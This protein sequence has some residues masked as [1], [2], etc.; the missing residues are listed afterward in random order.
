MLDYQ[1]WE[2]YN[3]MLGKCIEFLRNMWEIFSSNNP[4][5]ILLAGSPHGE[6]WQSPRS[7]LSASPPLPIIPILPIL[8]YPPHPILNL[9]LFGLGGWRKREGSPFPEGIKVSR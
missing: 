1:L 8:P 2:T 6:Y 5:L 7:K 4:D 9:R 3:Y